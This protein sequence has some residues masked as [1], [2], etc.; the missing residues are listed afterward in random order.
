[1]VYAYFTRT[2]SIRQYSGKQQVPGKHGSP[3][4]TQVGVC[5]GAVGDVVGAVGD[6]VC[7]DGTHS[8]FTH[9]R[10]SQQASLFLHGPPTSLQHTLLVQSTCHSNPARL[11]K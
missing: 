9:S 11:H 7:D 1:M 6:F 5:V 4:R 2:E 10:L 8:S 3:P